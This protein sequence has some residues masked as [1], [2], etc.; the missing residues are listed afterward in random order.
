MG[1]KKT[2]LTFAPER[3]V[4]IL[5]CKQICPLL[6]RQV[7][8]PSSKAVCDTNILGKGSPD[9]NKSCQ[10]LLASH[11]EHERSTENYLPMCFYS[12][13]HVATAICVQ[14]TGIARVNLQKLNENFEN[15]NSKKAEACPIRMC[16]L[17][18][19]DPQAPL[20]ALQTDRSKERRT[21]EHLCIRT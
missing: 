15:C 20:A 3:D 10:C 4:I 18:E 1:H 8:L 21:C 11:K 2:C 9:Q 12:Q 14:H 19:L 16:F 7:L 5:Y 6:C 13:N 17:K